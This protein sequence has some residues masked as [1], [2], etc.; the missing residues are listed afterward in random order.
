M[1]ASDSEHPDFQLVA[2][3]MEDTPFEPFSRHAFS[4]YGTRMLLIEDVVS[5]SLQQELA[6][7]I[8]ALGLK[9]ARHAQ[10]S[11]DA[12]L[13]LAGT[14]VPSASRF[15]LVGEMLFPGVISSHEEV[16]DLSQLPC[17]DHF[18]WRDQHLPP[19]L[20]KSLRLF[21]EENP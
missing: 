18:C 12:D 15:L 19:N 4:G 9:M 1:S 6:H 14:V 7:L 16:Q 11:S 8:I 10:E 2:N 5:T 20:Q 13:P 17:L 3:P 21:E